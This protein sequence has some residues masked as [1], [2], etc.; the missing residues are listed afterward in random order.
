MISTWAPVERA[1]PSAA[2]AL[3][4]AHHIRRLP[5]RDQQGGIAGWVTLADLSRKLLVESG[6]LQAAL[7]SLG[8]TAA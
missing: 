5:V 2:M 3:L 4:A 1:R 8:T 7:Q 6:E